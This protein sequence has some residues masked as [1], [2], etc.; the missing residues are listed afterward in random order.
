LQLQGLCRIGFL[1]RGQ[2][3]ARPRRLAQRSQAR[4]PAESE[5]V[6]LRRIRR[7]ELSASL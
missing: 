3:R 2:V 7:P 1:G 4:R 5:S 6:S